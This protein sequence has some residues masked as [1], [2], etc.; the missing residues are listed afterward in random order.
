M[1]D[2]PNHIAWLDLETTGTDEQTGHILEC[3]VIL[4]DFSLNEL[5]RWERVFAAPVGW[6]SDLNDTV[7]EMHAASGLIRDVRKSLRSVTD[8]DFELAA[9]LRHLTK[10]SDHIALAGS[11]VAHFD[12]RWIDRHMPLTAKRF[13]YWELDVGVVRRFAKMLAGQPFERAEVKHRA[14]A[15]VEQSLSEAKRLIDLFPPR[16]QERTHE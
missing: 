9:H 7:I 13:T 4:T 14:M 2:G 12:R 15:D 5:G 8:G 11:G 1:S 16:F 10:S 6:E 3:A